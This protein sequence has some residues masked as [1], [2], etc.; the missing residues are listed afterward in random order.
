MA[1]PTT[2]RWEAPSGAGG[3]VDLRT[4]RE[5]LDAVHRGEIVVPGAFEDLGIRLLTVEDGRVTYEMTLDERHLNA[6]G[7]AFG[8]VIA[9]LVDMAAG[10]AV[11]TRTPPGRVAPTLDMKVNFVRPAV[12]AEPLLRA[13][14]TVL[15]IDDRTALADARV[16]DERGRLIAYGTATCSVVPWPRDETV[17]GAG[18]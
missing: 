9:A 11:I 16:V 1:D 6:L 3:V 10:L 8:G 5:W 13:E 18:G 17:T 14:G 12:L 7:V 4:G 2:P 15:A